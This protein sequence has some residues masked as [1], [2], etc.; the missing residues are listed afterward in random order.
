M[1]ERSGFPDRY[2][3]TT[4]HAEPELKTGRVRVRAQV[5]KTFRARMQNVFTVG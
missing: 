1:G 2:L 5:L 4:E 3:G